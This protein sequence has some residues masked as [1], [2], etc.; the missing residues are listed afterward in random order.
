MTLTAPLKILSLA[1]ITSITI[2]LMTFVQSASAAPLQ[3]DSAFYQVINGPLHMLDLDTGDYVN[4]GST[5]SMQTNAIGYNVEDSYIYGWQNVDTFGSGSTGII[6]I[7]L[8][9]GDA[10]ATP[11]GVPSGMVAGNY[12]A[13]DF[14]LSGNHYISNGTL[15]YKID[16]TTNSATPVTLSQALPV[17]DI[18]YLDG[19]FYGTNGTSLYSVDPL[20]GDVNVTPLGL[21]ATVYGAGFATVD[22][23]LF[24]ARNS[25]G[26]IFR[27]LDYATSNPTAQFAIQGDITY[28][29]DG[30]SCAFAESPIPPINAVDDSGQ[31]TINT[32]LTVSADAGLLANDIGEGRQVTSNTQPANGTVVVNADG[33]YDYTPNQDF[34]GADSFT[35]T[36]T[37]DFGQTRT[38]TVTLNVNANAVP[39]VDV[40][41]VSVTTL[42][43]TGSSST[44]VVVFAGIIIVLGAVMA[45]RRTKKVLTFY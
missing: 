21:A 17:N 15:M 37:D 19:M 12:I 18:V 7:E 33:S 45:F 25:D 2:G 23:E 22:G 43:E 38:A 9:D 14:D 44:S 34:V 3:C 42:P 29:N 27:I 41:G 36:I 32:P 13:G 39:Q 40:K 16:V 26:Q 24:F 6:R 28:G 11:L 1:I 5:G 10:V 20:T 30:A 35:Y 4:L 8:V 31:T